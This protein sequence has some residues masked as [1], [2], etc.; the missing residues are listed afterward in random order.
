[1]SYHADQLFTGSAVSYH[2]NKIKFIEQNYKNGFQDGKWTVWFEDGNIQK[3][4]FK[5]QKKTA[6]VYKEWYPNK[7]LKYLKSYNLGGKEGKWKSWYKN[8]QQWTERDFL[9]NQLN[10]KVLVWDEG[11][12]LTKEDHYKK[13]Q[14]ILSK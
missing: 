8:G 3:E 12:I 5:S 14:L 13:G 4:G 10:G 9:K 6:G 1:M 11:G 7:Q 2:K